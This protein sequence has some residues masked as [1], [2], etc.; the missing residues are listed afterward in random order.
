M[1]R[2]YVTLLTNDLY[3]PGALVVASSL[4]LTRTRI[5]LTCILTRHVTS[6]AREELA[7]I[8]D[9]IIEVEQIDSF[10]ESR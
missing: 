2:S 7:T 9:N 8:F 10:D 4:R 6:N 5:P 1:S 3:L